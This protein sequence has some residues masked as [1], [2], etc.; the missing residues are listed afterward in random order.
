MLLGI[1]TAVSDTSM[2]RLTTLFDSERGLES[3]TSGRSDLYIA[4]WRMFRENPLGVGTGGFPKTFARMADRDLSFTGT[5]LGA[6]SAWVKVLTENG[7]LGII[8]LGAYVLSFA[9]AGVRSRDPDAAAIGLLVT[10]ILATAFFSRE[11]H[12][13]GLWLA[14][15][16]CIA[17]RC[18]RGAPGRC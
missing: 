5:E 18:A 2:H 8:A 6:H 12:S 10:M 17:M 4:G 7:V 3:R 13:K 9:I 11:F 1:F 15:A 16:G 14:A